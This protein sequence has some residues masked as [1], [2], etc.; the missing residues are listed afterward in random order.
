MSLIN[1]I[2]CG[3]CREVLPT[4]PAKLGLLKVEPVPSHIVEIDLN[5]PDDAQAQKLKAQPTPNAPQKMARSKKPTEEP[6]RRPQG[7]KRFVRAV[8]GVS[9]TVKVQESVKKSRN[10]KEMMKVVEDS[11]FDFNRK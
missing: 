2:A 7:S 8:H 4:L 9:L 11:I 6:S 1:T 10:L 5:R 3:D